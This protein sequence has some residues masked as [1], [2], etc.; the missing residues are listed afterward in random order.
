VART[1]LGKEATQILLKLGPTFIKVGQLLSTRIDIVPKEYIETLRLLQDQVPPFSGELAAEI[2]ERELGKPVLEIFDTFNYTS[3]AAASLGQVHVATK[4]KKTFAVKVQRQY[5]RELF[6]VDLKNLRQLA[7]FLDA[8]DPKAEGSL[9]DQNCQRD[10]VSI[11]EESARLLYEEIDYVNE[12]KNCQLFAENFDKPRFSHIKVPDTYPEMS[13]EKVMTMEFCPGIKITDKEALVKAGIDPVDIGVKSAQLFLESLCR[14]GFFHCDPHP[15]NLAVRKAGPAG[16]ATIIVYDFGMMDFFNQNQRK[17]FIDFIFAF[18]EN[19]VRG[20]LDALEVLGILRSGPDV[21]RIAVE[22]VGKD[23]MDRF[24]ETLRNDG[25]WDGQMSEEEKKKANRARRA[26]L[27][28]E[29]LTMNTDV[30]F[31]FPPTFTFV[32]RAFMSLDGIGKSLDPK[33]DMTRIARPYLKELLDLKDGSAAKTVA[34][35]LL[36]RVGLR[37]IDVENA[38]TQPRKTAYIATVNQRLERGEFKLRVRALEAE[39]SLARADIVQSNTFKATL[40]GLF[41]NAALAMTA[42]GGG[43]SLRALSKVCFVA[44]TVFGVQV[45]L[46]MR[47]LKTVDDNYSKFNVKR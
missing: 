45:P 20:A 14:N 18:Y 16:Q 19:D 5:L 17:G 39:R 41:L 36:Q 11:Y 38:V 6:A 27:G 8:T 29:F 12:V 46:G 30:P 34:L 22:R 37:P 42:V 15:G 2:I 9:L 35:K 43:A 28:E 24:Q 47:K 10:W 33:Y 23:F 3:L 40:A 21:D 4:G 31:V 1:E 7:G 13:T 25:D 26:R 32:F 44:G